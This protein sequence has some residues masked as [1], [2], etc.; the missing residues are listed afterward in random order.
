MKIVTWNVN[1]IR[2]RLGSVEAWLRSVQPDVVLLQ[3]TK[4]VEEAFPR[5]P[6]EDL[7]YNIALKGQKSYNGVA[8]LS[9]SPIEDVVDALPGDET[10]VQARYIEGVVDTVRVASIYVPNG[11]EVGSEKYAYKMAFM[12]RLEA[13]VQKLLTY[14]E[15]FVLGGDYNIAPF[16]SDMH[17][18]K[19]SGTDR[20]LCSEAEQDALR[21]LL[22][23]GLTD[24]VR[25][26]H[27]EN[28]PKT[29]NLFSWWDYRAGSYETN[30]GFRIDHLL[31]SP[32]AAD[33]LNDAGIDSAPRGEPK[34]S[35]HAPTWV[36]LI[37]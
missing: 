21:R 24:G 23:K 36:S 9:K 31:L 12:D 4:C 20:I 27:P 11:Q 1:S 17:N 29:Q 15:A 13:H 22:N 33:R 14:E 6:F 8:I 37:D 18:P 2:A 28:D 34:A 7:G 10:D 35:D 5:E 3:E 26:Y 25:V 32:Q 19:L 30:K 16:P